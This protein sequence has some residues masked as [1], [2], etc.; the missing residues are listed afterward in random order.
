MIPSS[1]LERIR[2]LFDNTL[3]K[4]PMGLLFWLALFVSIVIITVSIFV[5]TMG[6]SSKSSILEQA[7]L[8][9]ISSF[10]AADADTD[11]TWL[12]RFASLFVMFSGI[13][14]MGTLISILTTTID[15]K[16]NQLR[17]GRSRIIESDHTII[18]GWSE[19]ILVLIKELVIANDNHPNSCITILADAD[20]I[21]MEDKIHAV[22]DAKCKTRIVCRS[23]NPALILDLDLVSINTAKSIVILE[24][25]DDT[26]GLSIMKTILAIV[27]NPNRRIEPYHIVTA[28][29]NPKIIDSIK[30]ISED[31]VEIIYKGEFISKIEAQTLLQAGLSS[32]ITDLL[33]FEGDEIYFQKQPELTGKSYKEIALSYDTSAVIGFI[34]NKGDV[35]LNPTP[36]TKLGTNDQIIA[37]S[38]DDDTIIMSD[39]KN[40]TIIEDVISHEAL[41]AP[42]PINILMLGWNHNSLALIQHLSDSTPK[43]SKIVVAA[44][45]AD[46]K[47]QVEKFTAL[48]NLTLEHIEIDP[49]ERSQLEGLTY[50]NVDHVAILPCYNVIGNNKPLTLSQLDANTLVTLLNIQ[51]IRQKNDYPL[52]I[53][54]EILD[55][56]NRILVNS[57]DNDDFVVSDH[58]ISL[59]LAQV[60]EN[61]ALGPVFDTLFN[62]YNSEIYLKPITNYVKIG[63][64]IN[65]LTVVAA[66]LQQN[67][68]VIGYRL[69]SENTDIENNT[70]LNPDKNSVLDFSAKDKIIVLAE[71]GGS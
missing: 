52:T 34:T 7:Y 32:V 28:V 31:E 71:N 39:K 24:S 40:S 10:G 12:F 54:S 50:D 15:G 68:T 3:S 27:N 43:G 36:D 46:S 1:L 57:A 70:V 63:Q 49:T 30:L 69:N 21:E 23:G 29:D 67:E 66:G 35:L 19:E 16:I 17:R 47:L 44:N 22:L 59:A 51:H 56:K 20:K 18:L 58:L 64:P 6:V 14:V 8:Y 45:C 42:K 61:K 48:T 13:F 33:D 26:S 4:G 37:I 11:G 38:N 9:M 41:K 62:P 5:W 60:S 55:L 53:T 2:Y 65:F 25:A